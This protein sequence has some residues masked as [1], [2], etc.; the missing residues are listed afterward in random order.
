MRQNAVMAS[1]GT[2]REVPVARQFLV[3]QVLLLA[4]LVAGAV[5]L[6]WYDARGDVRSEARDRAVAVAQAVADAPTVV[7]AF[8]SADPTQVLQPY[9]E[10]VRGEADVDFVV[11]MELDRTRYTHPEPDRIGEKFVGDLGGAPDGYVFTQQFTGTLGPSMRA[12]VPVERDGSVIGLVSVGI[13]ID[14]ISDRLRHDL[15]PILVAGL[16]ALVV[17]VVGTGL[18]TRRL[19]RQTHG[20]GPAELS[21]MYEYHHAVLHA[22]RE[23]LLLLDADDRVQ[24]AND[25]AAD[26]LGLPDDVIGRPLADLDL[27]PGLIAAATGRTVESDDVYVVGDRVLVVSSAPAA[28]QGRDVGAVVTLRD[29]TELRSVTGELDTVRGLTEALRAQNHEA[30]NRLHTIVS[31]VEIG[32]TEEAVEFATRELEVAQV[33]TDTMTDRVGEPVLAALLLGKSAEAR[34]RGIDLDLDAVAL[35]A[36]AAVEPRDLVTVI[37]NLVDNAFDAVVGRGSARVRVRVSED[38]GRVVLV[39]ED[40]G[41]GVPAGAEEQVT[42]RGWSTKVSDAPGG[43]GRGIGL[44]L[45]AQVARRYGGG[46]LVG[47][48]SLGGASFRVELPTEVTR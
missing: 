13:K 32:R 36:G 44:A 6:S 18:L 14:S 35:P 20:L 21:R 42:A 47:R 10:E 16:L 41:D 22:V 19:A 3:L 23:G 15:V 26:L 48:S 34:E 45:V 30:A 7:D 38:A 37:G 12:V 31:L 28:W 11:V 9:A 27:P 39:V 17:G 2:R 40:S 1:S 33:L 5:V 29:H 8:G 25:E 24:L 4:I 43:G 46:V